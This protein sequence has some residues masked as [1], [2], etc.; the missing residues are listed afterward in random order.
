MSYLMLESIVPQHMPSTIT[1]GKFDE[2]GELLREILPACSD[3]MGEDSLD[4]L[5]T[6]V[7]DAQFGLASGVRTHR[8]ESVLS[9]ANRG[10]KHRDGA[11]SGFA[12]R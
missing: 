7:V 4:T 9:C 3:W 11:C 2:A 5:L 10:E 6:K 12:D 1:A 8:E